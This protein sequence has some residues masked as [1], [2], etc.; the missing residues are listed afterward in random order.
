M[1]CGGMLDPYTAMLEDF[2]A[3]FN[4]KTIVYYGGLAL[5]LLMVFSETGL[6][7]GVLFPG[8]SL[9]FTAGLL[10]S[11]GVI[12]YPWI[13]VALLIGLAA[14]L[15]DQSSYW[16]GWRAGQTI[17]NKKKS[18]FFRPEYGEMTRNFYKKYNALILIFGKFLPIIRTFAP[19]L[20]GVINMHYPVFLS[21]SLLG[22]LLWPLALVSV[23]YYLGQIPWVQAYY[24]WIILGLVIGTTGPILL[25][26]IQI[27]RNRNVKAST[28]L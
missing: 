10:T 2:F 17:F 7:I 14:F 3:L 6:F 18:L 20:A 1:N 13:I 8:D 23:G 26:L 28:N 4:P 27:Y 16:I 11:A 12:R 15:G 5:L 9:L 22:S 21:V 25:R 19:A 24:E